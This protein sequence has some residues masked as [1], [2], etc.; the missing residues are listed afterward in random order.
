[1]KLFFKN[2]DMNDTGEASSIIG[3]EIFRDRF[4]GILGLS[5]RRYIN[6]ILKYF[7]MENC[8]P[9]NVFIVKNKKLN[10]LQCPKSVFDRNVMKNIPYREAIG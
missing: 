6:R 3:I 10:L 7:G 5:Q 8:S 2:F 4:H 9:E 1:K